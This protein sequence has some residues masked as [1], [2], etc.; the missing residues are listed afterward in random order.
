[1]CTLSLVPLSSLPLLDTLLVGGFSFCPIW[2]VMMPVAYTIWQSEAPSCW[3]V[4][5]S[6]TQLG[7][8]DPSGFP[9][10]ELC[11]PPLTIN[12]SAQVEEQEFISKVGNLPV[13]AVILVHSNNIALDF[14]KF[15]IRTLFLDA[16]HHCGGLSLANMQSICQLQFLLVL[17]IC[18]DIEFLPDEVGLNLVQLT[19]LGLFNSYF[20]KLPRTLGN[21]QKLQTLDIF[22]CR[23]PSEIPIEVLKIQQLKHLL[24]WSNNDLKGEVRV[25]KEIGMLVNF[26]TCAGVYA[27]DVIANELATLTQLRKLAVSSVSEDHAVDLA[28]A[29]MKMENLIS[30]SL[31]AKDAVLGDTWL[32]LFPEFEPFSPPYLLLEVELVGTLVDMPSWLASMDNLTRL[33]LE[34]SD[35]SKNQISVLQHLPKLKVL[36]LWSAFNAK[37]IGKDFCKA[38][39]FPELEYLRISLDFFVEWTEVVNGAFPS[40]IFLKFVDCPT[41]KFLLE[42]LK[43][44]SKLQ[45]LEFWEVHEDLSR[46]LQGEENYKIKHIS[47]VI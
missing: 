35:L 47:K 11:G 42:G 26:Q 21:L 22:S 18:G 13:R 25:P 39:G 7:G 29:I 20:P 37:M 15:E 27:G 31:T 16:G 3:F 9:G 14:K 24:L 36:T 6:G 32:N 2:P 33:Y 12:C 4:S 38:R 19:Y 34:Y 30:L 43:N 45:I 23:S 17:E 8:F 41:L 10:N 44:I 46:R 5:S 40:L 1:M 28:S